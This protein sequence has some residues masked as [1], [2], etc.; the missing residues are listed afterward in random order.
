VSDDDG[1]WDSNDRYCT[2]VFSMRFMFMNIF[3]SLDWMVY[4][5]FFDVD[6]MVVL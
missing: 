4:V 6:D 1:L 2:V 5:G 3:I